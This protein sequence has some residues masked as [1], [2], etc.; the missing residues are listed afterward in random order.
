MS[1]EVRGSPDSS[2]CD[3]SLPNNTKATIDIDGE[4]RVVESSESKFPSL[5]PSER[6]VVAVDD[7]QTAPGFGDLPAL[8]VL[9][10]QP[11]HLV[12]VEADDS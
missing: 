10:S 11:R 4:G 1:A 2:V 5:A 12:P 6:P 9:V 3:F 7:K 8:D